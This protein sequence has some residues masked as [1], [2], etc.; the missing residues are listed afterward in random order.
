MDRISES[1]EAA[2]NRAG[3]AVE[4]SL[5]YIEESSERP[6]YYAYEPPAG[7]PRS[8]GKFLARTVPIRNA[9]EVVGDLSLDI[10]GFR[11]THQET[12][13]RDFYDQKEVKATYYP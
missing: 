8:T 9:R 4:A 12:A 11:L 6:V 2:G 7:T 10:Q 1:H 5:N 13:V 3:T